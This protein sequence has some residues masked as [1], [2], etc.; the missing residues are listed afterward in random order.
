MSANVILVALMLE[1]RSEHKF[2]EAV[3]RAIGLATVDKSGCCDEATT[4]AVVNGTDCSGFF[5][6]QHYGKIGDLFNTPYC[7]FIPFG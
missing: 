1:R 6:A 4:Y 5:M 7:F 2:L 3:A